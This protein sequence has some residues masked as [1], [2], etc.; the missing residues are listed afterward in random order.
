MAES[1]GRK[2]VAANV[3]QVQSARRVVQ[4]LFKASN[5]SGNRAAPAAASSSG[6]LADAPVSEGDRTRPQ[7]VEAAGLVST[8]PHAPEP[9]SLSPASSSLESRLEAKSA[10]LAALP[11]VAKKDVAA[12]DR[13]GWVPAN[14]DGRWHL[15]GWLQPGGRGE[16]RGVEVDVAALVGRLG[17]A[18]PAAPG[19]GEGDALRDGQGRVLHQ[20]GAVPIR[21]GGSRAGVVGEW[22]AAEVG[23]VGLLAADGPGI[24]RHGILGYRRAA[25]GDFGRGDSGRRIA[26]AEAGPTERGGGSAKNLV[27]RQRF[28]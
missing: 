4:D 13:S 24:R 18:L 19:G 21:R 17:G 3:A 7:A 5:A 8:A 28:P 14:G 22:A 26:A 23:S 1:V 20:A 9:R 15:F 16:I 25:R 6:R 11:V 10:K 2:E 12:G 27:R